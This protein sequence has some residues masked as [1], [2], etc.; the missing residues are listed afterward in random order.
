[1]KHCLLLAALALCA[2]PLLAQQPAEKEKEKEEGFV[3]LFD[4]KSFDGWNVNEKTPTSWKIDGGLLI[5]TGGRSHLFT[6]DQ[7]EDFIVRFEWRPAKKGYNSGFFV[8]GRQIQMAQGGAGMLF[9]AKGTRGVP[10]LHKPPHILAANVLP[11]RFS[12]SVPE[13]PFP[14]T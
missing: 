3:P 1:M 5:L 11:S 9:G 6:K 4:G 7:F 2:T 8:R 14:A 10:Q 12:P 13:R